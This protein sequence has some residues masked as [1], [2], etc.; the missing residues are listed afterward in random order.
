MATLCPYITTVGAIIHITIM[1]DITGTV[2]TIT[3]AGV[4]IDLSYWTEQV[5]STG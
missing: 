3:A 5:S 2:P 1:A 4:I